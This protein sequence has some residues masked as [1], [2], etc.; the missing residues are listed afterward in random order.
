MKKKV[1]Y[2]LLIIFSFYNCAKSSFENNT[3]F[4]I[5]G[6][7]FKK[8][9]NKTHIIINYTTKN[10][11]EFKELFFRG[12]KNIIENNSKL[13]KTLLIPLKKIRKEN[14]DIQLHH[15]SKH[16]FGNKPPQKETQFP[17][18]LKANE[19]ILSYKEYGK[20]KYFKIKNIEK[21]K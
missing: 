3:P 14:F 9:N 17:F 1:L 6:A 20:I 16:E 5:S 12:E 7:F 4:S 13:E 18:N 19:A 11:V 8:L 10:K 2:L 15:N 21:E